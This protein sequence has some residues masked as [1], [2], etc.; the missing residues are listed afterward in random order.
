MSP[1]LENDLT[2]TW[3]L[4]TKVFKVFRFQSIPL[5]SFYPFVNRK[6]YLLVNDPEMKILQRFNKMLN[7]TSGER[8]MES[9]N[10]LTPIRILNNNWCETNFYTDECK[11]TISSYDFDFPQCPTFTKVFKTRKT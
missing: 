3:F 5:K 1:C 6:L 7:V 4:Y 2:E 9:M 8:L 10:N 11:N